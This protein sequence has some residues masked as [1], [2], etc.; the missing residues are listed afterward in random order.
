MLGLTIT[1]MLRSDL[2][3]HADG[4]P[5]SPWIDAKDSS[6]DS[7]LTTIYLSWLP[8]KVS[9]SDLPGTFPLAPYI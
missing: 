5:L 8:S 7:D 1:A 9:L 6:A 2:L 4:L 3:P